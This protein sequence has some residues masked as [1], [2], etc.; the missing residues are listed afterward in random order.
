VTALLLHD[1]IGGDLVMG[2]VFLDGGRRAEVHLGQL[3][4]PAGYV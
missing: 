2:E 4:P 1:I 3:H